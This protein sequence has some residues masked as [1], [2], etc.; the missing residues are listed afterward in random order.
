MA[1]LGV[2]PFVDEWL[3]RIVARLD[4]R[5]R[6]QR[7]LDLA[8]G[9]GRH[10]VALASAGFLAYAVDRDIERL[11]AARTALGERR[12]NAL[13]WAAD[14]DTYPL[15]AARFDLLLCTRFLLRR[16]WDDL[17]RSVTPGG[18]VLYETFTAGQVAR[19]FGPSSPDHLLEPGE[20]AAAFADWDILHAQEVAEPAA[21][22][23]LVAR[24]PGAE[25]WRP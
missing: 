2:S 13:Q 14:L 16:R 3:P 22:A 17:K 11:L 8:A 9:R 6:P 4:G 19:G 18:F 1:E 7:A 12:L 24:K 23:T 20:L 25:A 10:L 15:P 21:L 5:G